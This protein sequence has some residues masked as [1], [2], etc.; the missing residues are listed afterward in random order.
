MIAFLDSSLIQGPEVTGDGA[1][2][3]RTRILQNNALPR[4]NARFYRL[5]GAAAIL[6]EPAMRA[7]RTSFVERSLAPP[8]G[9]AGANEASIS[10]TPVARKGGLQ[11][12]S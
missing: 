11:L 5:I 4:P 7:T 9:N 12:R 6:Q 2:P 10:F 3:G 1:T 8:V